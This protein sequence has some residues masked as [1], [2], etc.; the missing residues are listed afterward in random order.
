M[1]YQNTYN[2]GLLRCARNDRFIMSSRYTSLRAGGEA[3]HCHCRLPRRSLCSL[4]A[5]TG[6]VIVS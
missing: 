1:T 2:N 3:I 4:L 6:Y 5:M